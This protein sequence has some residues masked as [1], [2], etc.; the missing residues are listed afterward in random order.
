MNLSPDWLNVVTVEGCSAKHWSTLGEHGATN[1]IIMKWARDHA[2]VIVT[3]DL[4]F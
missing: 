3:H 1:E 2:Y 4:D